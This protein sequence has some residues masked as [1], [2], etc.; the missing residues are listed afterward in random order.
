MSEHFP[1]P[2]EEQQ[3]EP[4]VYAS[5]VKRVWAW[6]GIVYMVIITI[7]FTYYL[8]TTL[9]VDGLT[10]LMLVPALIGIAAT[11]IVRFHS[12]EGRGGVVACI[13]T[14]AAAA[15]LTIDNLMVGIPLLLSSLGV[16]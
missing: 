6:V 14:V 8:A 4:V 1:S 3:Q 7:T 11:A 10:Q 15:F 12:G 16:A 2:E 9:I 13:I 5:P